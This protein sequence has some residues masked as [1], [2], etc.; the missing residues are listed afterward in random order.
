M[1]DHRAAQQEL[2][3]GVVVSV[4]T[5]LVDVA[6]SSPD[7]PLGSQ[8]W[9]CSLRGRLRQ[10]PEGGVLAGDRVRVRPTVPGE[11]V[12]EEILPRRGVLARPRVANMD[13]ALVV[14]TVAQ[15]AVSTEH[16]DRLLCH[17]HAAGLDVCL[18][19]NKVD[20]GPADE[21][22]ERV[23]AYRAL[24]YPVYPVSALTGEGIEDL[25]RGPLR[26][27]LSVLAGPSGVGKSSLLTRLTG[28]SLEVGE[29]SPYLQ[30]GR[31][32]TRRVRLLAVPGG[33]L[34]ADTPG[35]TALSLE[36]ISAEMLAGAFPEFGRAAPCR[37]RDCRHAL[38]PDCGVRQ[39]VD[40]GRIPSWRYR[41]Y[42][43]FLAEV[44]GER[45]R[46]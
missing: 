28:V 45:A 8:V 35:F 17:V 32:T 34:A 18:V 36:G 42:L 31:H 37:F 1:K 19:V 40:E 41:H 29:L 23:E 7:L 25:R 27:R 5:H 30:R 39:A 44:G 24:G 43:A 21:V 14:V 13:Q 3:E 15:P 10:S 20:L 46:M 11:G 9:R 26:D 12:V 4:L 33:G 16:V 38:E 6:L 22:R 2:R